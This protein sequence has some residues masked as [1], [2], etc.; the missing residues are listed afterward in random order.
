VGYN[1]I[2][3]GSQVLKQAYILGD[4]N[5]RGALEAEESKIL[6]WNGIDHKGGISFICVGTRSSVIDNHSGCPV[7]VGVVVVP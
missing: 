2:C 1:N 7:G 5:E 6:G 4:A 3:I